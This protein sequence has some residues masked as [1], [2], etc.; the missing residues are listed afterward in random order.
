ML[1]GPAWPTST[2]TPMLGAM[3][4]VGHVL[5]VDR[6]LGGIILYLPKV[7]LSF[8]RALRSGVSQRS[9]DSNGIG[10]Y[11]KQQGS[12]DSD[13]QQVIGVDG[14]IRLQELVDPRRTIPG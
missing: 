7:E 1:I 9:V 6:R 2:S 4:W 14:D 3:P 5:P 8:D 13:L 10:V 12:A 11:G